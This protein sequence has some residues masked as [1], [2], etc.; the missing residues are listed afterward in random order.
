[1]IEENSIEILARPKLL[2]DLQMEEIK[3]IGNPMETRNYNENE[4]I[5]QE[6]TLGN[7]FFIVLS[8][9]VWVRK[10]D[11]LGKEHQLTVISCGE[12]FG[13][14][15]LIDEMPRSASVRALEKTRAAVL[16]RPSFLKMKKDNINLYCHIL[17]NIA[18]EFSGRLRSMDLKYVKL[19]NMIF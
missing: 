7:E 11:T 3:Y 13:E 14:M 12:C 18:I 10:K 16:T 1:V 19:I 9:S 2:S 17:E 8:G 6:G 5:F 15:A 4:D